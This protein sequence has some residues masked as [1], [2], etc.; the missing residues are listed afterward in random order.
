MDIGTQSTVGME[1]DKTLRLHDLYL[2]VGEGNESIT[3]W[4][5]NREKHCLLDG[6]ICYRN[7]KAGKI[8][9]EQSSG[10]NSQF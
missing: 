8:Q 4:T 3:K 9:G 2:L 1:T 7:S 6:N 5:D 10:R